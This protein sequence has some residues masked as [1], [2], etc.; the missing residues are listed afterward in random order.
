MLKLIVM[1]DLHILP[2]EEIKFGLDTA[3]RFRDAI[4]DVRKYY[5]D[6]DLCVYAWRYRR[7]GTA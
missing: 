5:D 4:S 2:P 3:A 1:S 7:Q 6:A